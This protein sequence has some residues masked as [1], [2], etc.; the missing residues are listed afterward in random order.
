MAIDLTRREEG[1]QKMVL[2]E[3]T[4]QEENVN[5]QRGEECG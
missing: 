1:V 5:V 4:E 3:L 2:Q